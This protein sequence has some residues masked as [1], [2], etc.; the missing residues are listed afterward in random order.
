MEWIDLI[1]QHASVRAFE[2]KRIP[3]QV[4]NQLIKAAQSG[5]S[6]NFLQAYSIIE[7]EEHQLLQRIEEISNCK[8]YIENTGAFYVFVADLYRQQTLLAQ[9]GKSAEHL[10][11]IEPFVVSVVDTAIAAQNLA[12]SAEA[13]GLGICYIG[14]I[15][16]NLFEMSELLHLPKYTYP[17]FG[18]S[19]GYPIDK[20]E[21]KPRLPQA[22]ILSK[23]TYQQ[24]SKE[25]LDSYDK[26]MTEYYSSRTTNQQT[27]SWQTKVLSYFS[28]PKR[29]ETAAFLKKQ[30]FHF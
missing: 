6:S 17:L 29:P 5:S 20:N 1:T 12:L 30:G 14:G 4:K 19:V 27:A 16:N 23:D 21:R 18:L 24:P 2:N 3:E 15:R 22:E 11:T 28:E 10:S 8:G 9:A 25:L 26:I 7:V 13:L